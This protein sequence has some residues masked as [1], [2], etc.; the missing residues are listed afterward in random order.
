MTSRNITN[1]VY[2]KKNKNNEYELFKKTEPLI[3]VSSNKKLFTSTYSEI[4]NLSDSKRI[5]RTPKSISKMEEINGKDILFEKRLKERYN[6]ILSNKN[7]LNDIDFNDISLKNSITHSFALGIIILEKA[8]S[9]CIIFEEEEIHFNNI[10]EMMQQVFDIVLEFQKIYRSLLSE[11]HEFLNK[12][13]DL[14]ENIKIL[15]NEKLRLS[16]K[17]EDSFVSYKN[18]FKNIGNDQNLK[19]SLDLIQ[20]QYNLEIQKLSS[21]NDQLKYFISKNDKENKVDYLEHELKISIE[22]SSKL[23]KELREENT[24]LTNKIMNLEFSNQNQKN[25]IRTYEQELKNIKDDLQKF[26][27]NNQKFESCIDILTEKARAYKEISSM[28]LEELLTTKENFIDKMEIINKVKENYFS[29]QSKLVSMTQLKEYPKIEDFEIQFDLLSE[30]NK[31]LLHNR[32]F[33][34]TYK[35]NKIQSNESL[36][37]NE[38]SNDILEPGLE[39]KK[40]IEGTSTFESIHNIDLVKFSYYQPSFFSLIETKYKQFE[41]SGSKSHK[42][43]TFSLINDSITRSKE[44][45]LALPS[46][47]ISIIRGIL[48]SKW[49]EFMFYENSRMYSKFPDFVYSWLGK[50]EINLDNR[51]VIAS[52]NQDP[53]EDRCQFLKNLIH[54]IIDKH[55]E[56]ITFREFLEEKASSDEIYFYLYCRFLFFKG[57][58][59]EHS[60][61]KFCFVHFVNFDIVNDIIEIVFK[62]FEEETLNFLKKKLKSKTK[63]KSNRVFIDSGFVLRIFLEY[64]RLERKHRFKLI[65]EL[66]LVKAQNKFYVKYDEFKQILDAF[67][68]NVSELEK[69]QL[70]RESYSV[71]HGKIDPEIVFLVL[72]E[73]HFFIKTIKTRLSSN[74][75]Q[76]MAKKGTVT[77]NESDSPLHSDSNVNKIMNDFL[78]L[79]QK[80]NEMMNVV[81]SFGIESLFLE[82]QYYNKIFKKQGFFENSELHGKTILYTYF[83]FHELLMSIRNYEIY[84][85]TSQKVIK[86]EE[87]LKT[88]LFFYENVYN[89]I[90]KIKNKQVI[91]ELELNA[92]AKKIQKWVQYRF[93]RWLKLLYTVF[94]VKLH[95]KKP[96]NSQHS[97]KSYIK[98]KKT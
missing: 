9:K 52:N 6:K 26:K 40:N 75:S 18:L 7:G 60:Q 72:S 35:K 22:Q 89:C 87:I 1:S 83:R 98:E 3:T 19:K 88:E 14:N 84:Q 33:A 11:N 93:S 71:G 64:Y 5:M 51:T 94:K 56:S 12:I 15:T 73:N 44:S 20:N 79:E 10:Y 58:Q 90:F 34:Q 46:H 41:L 70:Y 67:Q 77:Q 92:N 97:N 55:W 27:Q 57:P 82:T 21:E 85:K 76:V 45:N 54:P 24:I 74:A 38:K 62:S 31:H 23:I 49:N 91:Q 59:L 65:Q 4:L 25:V 16:Y 50:F 43:D 29:I 42:P 95:H 69:A 81:E 68:T 8:L 32:Y 63:I 30:I 17:N 78:N 96:N 80:I 13:Q 28:Q 53:D 47:F 86:E 39:I 61:G 36:V 2:E 37:F 66:F 48:D